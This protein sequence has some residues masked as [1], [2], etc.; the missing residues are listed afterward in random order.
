MCSVPLCC[1]LL[2]MSW[3]TFLRVTCL[4]WYMFMLD[5]PMITHGDPTQILSQ[6][7]ISY[8]HASD[9]CSWQETGFTIKFLCVSLSASLQTEIR[10][11]QRPQQAIKQHSGHRKL[12][13]CILIA[14]DWKA[15]RGD[16]SA[17]TCKFKLRPAGI[18]FSAF[19]HR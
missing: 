4:V 11:H 5:T 12:P 15:W 16:V 18:F 7:K 14:L 1:D 13:T 19:S 6:H 9:G 2:H 8:R 3:H 10:F 17:G